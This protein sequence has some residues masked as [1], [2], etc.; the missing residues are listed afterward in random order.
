MLVLLSLTL[1]F[2]HLY[3]QTQNCRE[4]KINVHTCT[5]IHKYIEK[6]KLLF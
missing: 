6:H 5:N 2:I 4:I 3:T 1:K